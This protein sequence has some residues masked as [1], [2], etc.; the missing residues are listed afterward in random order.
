M[1]TPKIEWSTLMEL[2]VPAIDDAHKQFVADLNRIVT[3]P[4]SAFPV[5][6]TKLV[7]RVERDFA[8]EEKLMEEIDF[9]AASSHREQHARVLSGLHHAMSR[10]MDGDIE[11]GRHA[12]N[13]LFEWF[14]V[15]LMTVD[16]AL[17]AAADVE[18]VERAFPHVE[19]LQGKVQG[20]GPTWDQ[21]RIA[22]KTSSHHARLANYDADHI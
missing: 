5:E 11:C 4:D 6:L 18:V 10:V 1:E 20:Y 3:E 15:H 13:L 17:A 21:I 14:Q 2:G 22:F 8:E 9:P 12:V 19:S 16:L 7:A